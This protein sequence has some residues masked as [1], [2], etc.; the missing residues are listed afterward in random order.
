MK[1]RPA[2]TSAF[3]QSVLDAE[4]LT[5]E[6]QFDALQDALSAVNR[7]IQAE[8]HERAVDAARTVF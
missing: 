8:T 5:L 2:S 1:A 7:K 6:Q 3:I 4:G